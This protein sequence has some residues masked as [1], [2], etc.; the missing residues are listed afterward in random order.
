LQQTASLANHPAVKTET[1][2]PTEA[3]LDWNWQPF[4]LPAQNPKP[5]TQTF[6]RGTAGEHRRGAMEIK[7]IVD[8]PG[9]GWEFV[10]HP[11]DDWVKVGV[12]GPVWDE[13]LRG[14]GGGGGD[15]KS[16]RDGEDA[17]RA[18]GG[19]AKSNAVGWFH[20]VKRTITFIAGGAKP[21][22]AGGG[23]LGAA[24]GRGG[25]EAEGRGGG[26]GSFDIG[27]DGDGDGEE[28]AS[29]DVQKELEVLYSIEFEVMGRGDE[30]LPGGAGVGEAIFTGDDDEATRRTGGEVARHGG[31][32]GWFD[33]TK[34]ALIAAA[35]R[36]LFYPALARNFA[37]NKFLADFHWWDQVDQ[38]LNLRPLCI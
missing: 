17:A 28:D 34:S 26:G 19:E 15:A 4:F 16:G 20:S 21:E 35:A 5:T 29:E 2:P 12:P 23:S 33:Y 7:E 3:K 32:G 14:G 11:D 38:V 25:D 24:T 13:D 10:E 6:E 31:D 22:E 1:Q 37:L 8:D 30:V 9:K 27:G 18:D 36:I